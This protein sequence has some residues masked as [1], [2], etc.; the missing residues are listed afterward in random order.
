[1]KLKNVLTFA[2]TRK[3]FP[4]FTFQI[5]FEVANLMTP[6]RSAKENA[7]RLARSDLTPTKPDHGLK[8]KYP[9]AT[10]LQRIRR[11]T[12]LLWSIVVGEAALFLFA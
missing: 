11:K 3:Q 4:V 7:N 2:V 1:M 5:Q 8:N 6:S 10:V 9:T 12:K